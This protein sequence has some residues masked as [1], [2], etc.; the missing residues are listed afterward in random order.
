MIHLQFHHIGVAG[1][2]LDSEMLRLA[3]L[4][5][6]AEGDV[7]CDPIQGVEGRF[8]VG[9][10]P[11][12]EILR[13]TTAKGVLT[14]WLK[15]GTKLYHLAYCVGD[16]MG[17]EIEKLRDHGAKIVVQP[18]SATAF[19]GADICFLMLPNMLLIELIGI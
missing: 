14:P 10:G 19:S 15:S 4:G 16:Q 8:L 6:S 5:Y 12:L 9:G 18:V 11:R 1:K 3:T 7:F 17:S 13:P 2:D